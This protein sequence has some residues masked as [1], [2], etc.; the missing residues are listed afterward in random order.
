MDQSD[1]PVDRVLVKTVI[2]EESGCWM[3]M[4]AR[5]KSGGYGVLTVHQVRY[6]AHRVTYEHFIGPVPDG[7]VLDHL[8]HSSDTGCPGGKDGCRHTACV[9]PDHLEA[10]S[11]RENIRRAH[12]GDLTRY[13]RH[14]RDK[15]ECPFGHPYSEENTYINKGK[16][17]CRICFKRRYAVKREKL[18]LKPKKPSGAFD[19]R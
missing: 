7:L 11:Q 5:A 4:G 14:E 18:G 9:N 12:W 6:R 10:V 8:C 17:Y 1:L 16:R 13:G 2:D 19:A 3:F 15:T